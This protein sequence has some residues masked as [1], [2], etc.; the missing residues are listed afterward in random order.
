MLMCLAC[1]AAEG[2]ES[3]CGLHCYQR[4][5]SCL[6]YVLM[7][8]IMRMSMICAVPRIHVEA[9]APVKGKKMTFAV[10][11][12]TADSQLRK[13]DMEDFRDNLYSDTR[14]GSQ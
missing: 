6:W 12:M 9:Y 10:V 2:Y 8:E 3:V 7:L 14:R 11:L 13:R 5:C 1:T 4:P